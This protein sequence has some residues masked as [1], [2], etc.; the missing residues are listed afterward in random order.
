MP[1]VSDLARLIKELED[2]LADCTRCGMC[3]A[4]CP[5]F[6]QTRREADVA[7]GKLALLDG[8]AQ[9][10]FTD[11]KGVSQRLNRCLLCGSC[12]KNCSSGVQV[13]DIFLKARTILAGYQGLP[14]AKK[15]LLQKLL[16]RPRLLD[17]LLEYGAAYQH[18]VAKPLSNRTG[19]SC[20]RLLT[21]P[22]RGRHFLPLA[23]TP[24][25]RESPSLDNPAGRSGLR[26]AFFPGC[27]LD[28]VLPQ[29]ARAAVKTLQFHQVGIYMPEGQACCG[30]PAI[31]GGDMETFQNLVRHNV[32]LFQKGQF[33]Y[34]VTAC[35]TCT[36]TLRKLWPLAAKRGLGPLAPS[37]LRLAEKTL[38]ISQFLASRFSIRPAESAS[39]G[40]ER[41]TYHDPCHLKKSI[42]VA[43][44]PR[45]LIACS[46]E[47]RLVEMPDA[48]ACCGMGGSFNI[49]HYDLSRQIGE[50]KR[51]SIAATGCRTV[52]TGCPACMMQL[53]DALS[54]AG[55]D[56]AVKH[57]IEIYAENL[58]D[59][60]ET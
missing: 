51:D 42:G 23:D 39:D 54:K 31:S 3:Q 38:D 49:E 21:L 44:E 45:S 14:P 46:P 2:Q 37:A 32:E 24:F 36:F 15:L 57:V 50:Q 12:E 40:A 53:A 29:V 26:V 33:D 58:E 1:T 34:L 25:H 5:V 16:G 13:V 9:E 48:D 28:K 41:I 30:I 8:L 17:R 22:L 20:G 19:T 60:K 55:D 27:L 35:A 18:L 11:P 6:G 56:V 7:R 52:A 47:R 10:M 43:A 4:V 59:P